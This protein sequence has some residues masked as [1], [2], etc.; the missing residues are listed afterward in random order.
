MN[1]HDLDELFD[2]SE[3]SS[4]I[5]KQYLGGHIDLETVVILEKVFG[6]CSQ[7]DKKLTDPVWET[8]SMKIKKYAPFINI[9]VLQYKKVLRETV[10]G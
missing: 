4:S 10:N 8:V 9:D 1:E 3:W 6:V 7:F 5:L 2:C